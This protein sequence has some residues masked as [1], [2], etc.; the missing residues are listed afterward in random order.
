MSET[1]DKGLADITRYDSQ[2]DTDLVAVLAKNYSLVMSNK[3][4][5]GVACSDKA[6]LAT[7][8]ENFLKKKLGLTGSDSELDAAVMEICKEMTADRKKSRLTFYYLLTKKYNKESV[9]V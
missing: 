2:P 1:Y 6:E 8:R 9:F 3:D 5:S 4:A 7:V